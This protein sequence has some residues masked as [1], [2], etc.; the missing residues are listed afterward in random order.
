MEVLYPE[1]PQ[2]FQA[3][4]GTEGST[5]H[6]EPVAAAEDGQRLQLVIHEPTHQAEGHHGE[7]MLVD[8]VDE[9]VVLQVP[10]P[11]TQRRLFLGT[12]IRH[13]PIS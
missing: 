6:I 1:T 5:A 7:V 9:V 3:G 4:N 8:Q 2:I 13:R 12:I 11:V 10:G